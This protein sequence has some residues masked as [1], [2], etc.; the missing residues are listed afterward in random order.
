MSSESE[1]LNFLI[2]PHLRAKAL[3][4]GIPGW[5]SMTK[6]QLITALGG[7]PIEEPEFEL[8]DSELQVSDEPE[9]GSVPPHNS[10]ETEVKVETKISKKTKTKK[11]PKVDANGRPTLR[12]S[13]KN[14]KSDVRKA[15]ASCDDPMRLLHVFNTLA[16]SD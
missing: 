14:L 2:V 6:A 7:R 11:P 4:A 10:Q 12:L 16:E 3:A 8:S 1:N 13:V 15:V 5:R 9:E